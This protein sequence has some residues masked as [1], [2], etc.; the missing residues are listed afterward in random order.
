[1]HDITLVVTLTAALAVAL[2]LGWITQRLGLSTLVGYLLA[3]IVVGPHTPGFVADATLA[4]RLAEIGV[5]LLMFSV[6]MHFHVQD[7][8]RVWRVAVP[9]AVAQ[10]VVAGV[11]GWL[12][13][14]AVGWSDAA[15]AVFG[16]SLAVASTAVL[17][18]MLIDHGRLATHGGHVAVGW[19]I[20]ED[21][22]TVIALVALPALAAA[23]GAGSGGSLG[24]ELL[25][26][27]GKAAAFAV[28]LWALGNPIVKRVIEPVARMRSEELFTLAV[29]VVALGIAV[30][31]A[32]VF[33]VSVAL[34]A[35]F[36]GLVV[37]RSRLGPQA[38]AYMSPFR[39][40][41]SALFFV[42]VGMLFDPLFP[43]R[44]PGLVALALA[45]VVVA[46][47]LAAWILVRALRDTPRTAATVAVGLSQIG[48]FSFLLGALGVSLGVLPQA[49]L[50][51]LVAAAIVSI[52]LNP[53][54]F[55]WLARRESGR[56]RPAIAT[57]ARAADPVAG[58]L[59]GHVVLCG[60]GPLHRAVAARL[61]ATEAAVTVIDDD[62]DFVS[63]Q[64]AAGHP[65]VYGQ[66][67]R[68]EVL[69][70]AGVERAGVLVIAATSVAVQMAIC[71]AARAVRPDIRIVATASDPGGQAWLVEFGAS[72]VVD[73]T[74][75]AVEAIARAVRQTLDARD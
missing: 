45:I 68:Q 17:M 6:G 23:G 46:K 39:D 64:A 19:L 9:G 30:I 44:E 47:P 18:R 50:D 55:R 36:A 69:R 10:S 4:S 14:K 21:V 74:S 34:G 12:V 63:A 2:V 66:A 73:V 65:A 49:G 25:A 32:G 31:A 11:C 42:S 56:Q 61:R 26:A 58:E 7:L 41:F 60:D 37:G 13:A 67:S 62:L 29:F 24:W 72:G 5:I 20:V 16:M 75:P 1:M 3:G 70:A 22:F 43:V 57:A 35:F 33:H 8:L 27:I 59:E 28:L 71:V 54:L 51:T 40:V 38:A 15:G 52:A 53:L 48:E